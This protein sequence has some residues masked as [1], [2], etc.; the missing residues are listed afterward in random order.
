MKNAVF[1]MREPDPGDL[2]LFYDKAGKPMGSEPYMQWMGPK[3]KL[4]ETVQCTCTEEAVLLGC[5]I[6]AISLGDDFE[7]L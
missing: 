4:G 3:M 7:G 2:V 5:P 6:H 1:A